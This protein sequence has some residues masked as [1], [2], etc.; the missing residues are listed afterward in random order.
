MNA[1]GSAVTQVVNSAD[2]DGA[3]NWSPDGIKI[4]FVSHRNGNNE[5]YKVNAE[6]DHPAAPDDEQRS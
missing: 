5:I 4:A 2:H 6:W 1:N 3:P